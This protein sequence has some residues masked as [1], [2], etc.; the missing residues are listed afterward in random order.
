MDAGTISAP[1]A[2][3][4]H[5][6]VRSVLGL[7]GVTSASS[8]RTRW[9][10]EPTIVGFRQVT[11]TNASGE[12][13]PVPM[14]ASCA[15]VPGVGVLAAG[16]DGK[17]G[18]YDPT[19][20][21]RFWSVQLPAP[22]YASL[23]V[24]S[25]RKRVLAAT[26]GGDLACFDLKGREVWRHSS[27]LPLYTMP[28]LLADESLVALTSFGS[29]LTLLRTDSGAEVF[30]TDLQSPWHRDIGSLNAARDPYA[31]PVCTRDGVVIGC[32]EHLYCFGPDGTE[33]WRTEV[34]ASVRATPV[35]L[36][37][38]DEIAAPLVD[39]RCLFIDA[40]SGQVSATLAFETKF[41]ASPAVSK[42]VLALGGSN[43]DLIGV[44]TSER[45][46]RWQHAGDA[47]V[48]HSSLTVLPDGAFICATG[49]GNV[50]CRDAETGSFTWESGQ[51]LGLSHN[52]RIDTTPVAS[53]DGRMFCTSYAGCLYSFEFRKSA[54]VEI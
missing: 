51:Q 23:V 11:H 21:K 31:T 48:D 35:F 47:P 50:I 34:G 7:G 4:R 22:V 1:P 13:F 53:P 33:H 5:D 3:F 2:R 49:R 19:F 15:V 30:R 27:P 20:A 42:G 54:T 44:D 9:T 36:V 12:T 25:A 43:G 52:T 17:L 45:T 28:T 39:G 40:V 32:A 41:V 26:T 18:L 14:C 46:V 29:R 38:T 16:Y 24:S 10:V 8:L 6:P 37:E